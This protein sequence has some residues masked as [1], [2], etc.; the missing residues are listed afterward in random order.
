MR[1]AAA[2]AIDA[3]AALE[4][5]A[6]A[7][8]DEGRMVG[9]YWLR[10]PELAP[11]AALR[12][13]IRKASAA[14]PLF[15]DQVQRGI[16]HGGAGP[17]RHVIHVGIGGSALG[18]QLLCES[19]QND[20]G[21]ITL[22]F[23]DNCDPDGVSRLIRRV[24]KDLGRTLV[25]VVS[26]SGWTPT[27]RRVMAELEDAYADR[28]LT[29]ARHAVATTM[30]GSELDVRASRERWLAR[31]PLW[32]WVGGRTS[33]TSA[34]GL[35]PA[36]LQGIDTAAVIRGAA[37]MDKLTRESDPRR[38][39]ATM[40]ALM[41]YWLGSG[42]GSKNMV[43]LPYRDRLA[44]F[45]RYVQQLVMESIGKR[46]DRAGTVVQQGL[47][48]YGH[49]G[50]TDQ[51]AYVQQLREGPD[52][53][54]VTFVAVDSDQDGYESPAASP[55]LGDHLFG[56]LE[57]MRDALSAARRDSITI[58]LPDAGPE[59]LG[60]LIALYER[61]VGLYAEL[62][63]VNAYHQPGVEKDI[64]APVLRLQAEVMEYLRRAPGPS[65]AEEVAAAIGQGDRAETVYKVLRRQARLPDT[66]IGTQP[67]GEH[68][69]D[70]FYWLEG[71][72]AAETTARVPAGRGRHIT[73]SRG[74]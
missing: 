55:S 3:M 4:A 68:F 6:V 39:P 60:A 25:S 49:K 74:Y 27:P 17:F 58:T 7:N 73:V 31:F 15:A 54:F 64:A 63:D 20:D 24:G 50:A 36:A 48:V 13:E 11:S 44:L 23:I 42:R 72:D 18:P 51:H 57:G 47:T 35:L 66:T 71:R 26:K 12:A 56:N 53:S 8:A 29:F 28:G 1:P 62:I 37:R 45:P 34:V 32:E 70:R 65:N 52:D 14:V 38:N 21:A 59:S 40:L 9:H 33:V 41:W 30:A 43:V 67:S 10:A 19:Q 61:A 46:L 2:S 69:S 16:V 22:D 5:G